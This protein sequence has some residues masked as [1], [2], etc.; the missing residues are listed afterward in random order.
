M[1]MPTGLNMPDNQSAGMAQS[2]PG[3]LSNDD[4]AARYDAHPYTAK[5]TNTNTAKGFP[6]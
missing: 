2:P 1:T 4:G 3:T 6:G 5:A